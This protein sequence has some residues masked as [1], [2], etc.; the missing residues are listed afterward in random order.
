MSAEK[1][2]KSMDVSEKPRDQSKGTKKL[3]SNLFRIIKSRPVNRVFRLQKDQDDLAE[4]RCQKIIKNRIKSIDLE[5][6]ELEP[7]SKELK[8]STG[9]PGF[10]DKES[11]V[12]SRNRISKLAA[13]SEIELLLSVFNPRIPK[14]RIF[15]KHN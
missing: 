8:L 1:E 4:E 10:T 13:S 3:S 2:T 7:S 9:Y 11:F 14:G 5:V 12:V 15:C 6:E